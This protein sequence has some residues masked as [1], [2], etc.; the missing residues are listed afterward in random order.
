MLIW[1]ELQ[2]TALALT[3]H[4]LAKAVWWATMYNRMLHVWGEDVWVPYFFDQ[5]MQEINYCQERIWSSPLFCGLGSNLL[6]GHPCSQQV[7][8]EMFRLL[9]RYL[10]SE[11]PLRTH[12]QLAGRLE[13]V[14]ASWATPAQIG[15]EKVGRSTLTQMGTDVSIVPCHPEAWM[16]QAEGKTLRRPGGMQQY[17]CSIPTLLQKA[18]VTGRSGRASY[19]K[20]ER[21]GK[22]F[23]AV[24]VGKQ[25]AIDSSLVQKMVEQV[26]ARSVDALGTILLAHGLLEAVDHDAAPR[27]IVLKKCRDMWMTHCLITVK[28]G[29]AQCT[30]WLSCWTGCCPHTY[31]VEELLGYKVWI[32]E[33]PRCEQS[34]GPLL[35]PEEDDEAVPRRKRRRGA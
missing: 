6:T 28:D 18:R 26:Q 25:K 24:A 13:T 8:E 19:G 34:Q 22:T 2:K 12:L 29:K 30:C 27:K 23:I 10:H 15:D 4:S 14:L 5:Y 31:F 16:L 3:Y 7:A 35:G 11:G 33:I 21:G 17:F 32:T 1:F 20:L 9:K